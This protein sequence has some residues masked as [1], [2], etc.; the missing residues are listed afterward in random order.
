MLITLPYKRLVSKNM[1][2]DAYINEA[3]K[4]V[5]IFSKIFGP[6]PFSIEDNLNNITLSKTDRFLFHVQLSFLLYDLYSFFAYEFSEAFIFDNSKFS[7]MWYTGVIYHFF[8]ISMVY[9]KLYYVPEH[10]TYVCE[11]LK[12]IAVLC[13]KITEGDGLK[14]Y[15]YIQIFSIFQIIFN[16]IPIFVRL[17][18][19]RVLLIIYYS[20]FL[21]VAQAFEIF[22][23]SL[24]LILNYL[25][26]ILNTKIN[27]LANSHLTIIKFKLL[28]NFYI[29]LYLEIL[30]IAKSINKLFYCLMLK[31]GILL[32]IIAFY[33]M[34]DIY[35][36][37]FTL[38][39]FCYT[40]MQIFHLF[41]IILLC[42]LL[43]YE[44]C[45]YY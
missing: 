21:L 30:T 12:K 36:N 42:E 26:Y 4:P 31:I 3:L 2:T 22:A 25:T 32:D 15:K 8:Y 41:I 43:K 37:T 1:T 23:C 28:F 40:S 29:N 9:V 34:F 11:T 13:V 35:R 6:I 19:D 7:N 27:S 44:V 18:R 39:S 24:L 5:R 17:T 38:K 20:I 10:E 45:I 14:I 16:V 33:T